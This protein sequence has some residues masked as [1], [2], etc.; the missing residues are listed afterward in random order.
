MSYIFMD[1]SVDL[2]FNEISNIDILEN[3]TFKELKELDLSYH[4]I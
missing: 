4:E 2:G 1:E 3:A